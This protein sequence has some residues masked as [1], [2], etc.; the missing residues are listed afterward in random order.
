MH[1]HVLIA[2]LTWGGAETLLADYAVGAREAGIEVSVG[3]LEGRSE[4]A[5]RLRKLGIEPTLVPIGSLLG[6]RDRRLVRDHVAQ[7]SPDLLHTHLGYSDFDG[8]LAARHLGIPT[9][10]TLHT[11]DVEP[12]L[13]ETTKARLMAFVRRR[14]AFRVIAVS[15]AAR[16]YYLAH[17][18]D[19]P[20]HVVTIHN[21]VAGQ[22]SP[23][24]GAGIRR[25]LG[26]EPDDLVVAMVGVLRE[27]K[28]H[29]V[30]G[31][32]IAALRQRFPKIRLLI[33]GDGPIRGEVER[34]AAG[35][36]N[37]AVMTGFR[38][39]VMDILDAVDILLH[40]SFVDALPTALI[41]AAA[42]RVPVVASSVGGI[43]EIVV[44]DETGL[45]VEAP[46]SAP[47]V[48]AALAA[49]LADPDLR[50]RMGN[51]GRERFE[52]HFTLEVWMSRLRALYEEAI[53]DAAQRRSTESDREEAR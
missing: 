44:A 12:T 36:G 10:A 7:V 16:Q 51:A 4:T 13:R 31:E 26:L 1:V 8:G 30:A 33:V 37:G 24:V 32:A 27:G 34:I 5:N 19:R 14:C 50:Q 3:Y 28:G 2:S 25:Q 52:G 17:A 43:P 45:L 15:E 35:L 22:V 9:V 20:E 41:E 21:G 49:L 6:R 18:R 47:R 46:P 11:M 39:D 42:A 48:V 40:P 23:G 29:Q 53:D 38:D